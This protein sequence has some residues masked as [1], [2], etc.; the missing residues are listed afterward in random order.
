MHAAKCVLENILRV[1][2]RPQVMFLPRKSMVHVLSGTTEEVI[3]FAAKKGEVFYIASALTIG[4]YRLFSTTSNEAPIVEFQKPTGAPDRGMVAPENFQAI[5]ITGTA[6][7]RICLYKET[8]I[9]RLT[10]LETIAALRLDL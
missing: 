10:L 7:L 1:V 8:D 3:P 2:A 6:N 5:G 4:R 9:P